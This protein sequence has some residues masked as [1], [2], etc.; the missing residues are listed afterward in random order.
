MD[1]HIKLGDSTIGMFLDDLKNKDMHTLDDFTDAKSNEMIC[2]VVCSSDITVQQVHQSEDRYKEHVKSLEPTKRILDA[3]AASK[4]YPEIL[5]KKGKEE[6]IHRFGRYSKNESEDFVQARKTVNN[7][8]E[9]HH[10]FHWELEMM[11][12]FTDK[13]SG[14]DLVVGNPPWDICRAPAIRR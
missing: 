4:I 11:D 10:F 5:P 12:A 13:R 7:L 3:L 8:A 9:Q 14:F 1:H 6:F 2:D